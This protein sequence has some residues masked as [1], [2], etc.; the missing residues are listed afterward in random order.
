MD[1]ST[2]YLD[3]KIN[4]K[5]RLF[6]GLRSQEEDQKILD[7]VM[8][9]C[10]DEMTAFLGENLNDEDQNSLLVDMDSQSEDEAEIKTLQNYLA[11]I[12]NYRFRLDKRLDYFLDNLLLNSISKVKQ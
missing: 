7:K 1:D 3:A 6:R 4:E 5:F 9:L 2:S 11:K 8:N 10:F 12:E